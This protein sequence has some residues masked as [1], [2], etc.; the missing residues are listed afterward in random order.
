[1][2]IKTSDLIDAA[3][4]WAVAKCEGF[5]TRNNCVVEFVNPQDSDDVLEFVCMAE[6][7]AHAR[8]Q[9]ENAYAEP[10]FLSACW[11]D[12]YS[13]STDWAKG[14]PIIGAIKG[15]EFKHWLESKPDTC[16]EAHIHNYEGDWIQFGP[17][18]LIA[19]LRCYVASKLGDEIDIPEEL[20]II[21]SLQNTQ[22]N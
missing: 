10:E 4:D 2:K 21:P 8:E 18:Q 14:G 12:D 5:D 20:S 1:M 16:C 15:F 9:L 7:E 22:S 13:P 17:T 19:A 6:D 11:K 3:L